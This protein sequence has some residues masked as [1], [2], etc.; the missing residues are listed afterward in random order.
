MCPKKYEINIDNA[1]YGQHGNGN[2][3]VNHDL[4]HELHGLGT[5]EEPSKL[6]SQ[7]NDKKGNLIIR[8]GVK[9]NGD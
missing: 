6:Q 5:T 4:N 2:I 8:E 3:H 1:K 9:I 7:N